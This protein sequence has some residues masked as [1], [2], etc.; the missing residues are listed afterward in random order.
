MM[1]CGAAI[2]GACGSSGAYDAGRSAPSLNAAGWQ[3]HSAPGMP[4]TVAGVHQGG[5]LDARVPDGARV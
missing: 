3:A 5:Y 4:Q 2:V 1:L